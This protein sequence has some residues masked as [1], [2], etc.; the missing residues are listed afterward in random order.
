MFAPMNPPIR[1]WRDQRVWIVGASSGIGAALARA[2]LTAGAR[3][4]LSARREQALAE[5][6]GAASHPDHAM[7][8]P[9][10]VTDPASVAAAHERIVERW[11]SV[12]LTIWVAGTYEAMHPHDFRLSAARAVIETNLSIYN[13]LAV[14]LPAM[15]REGRGSLAIVSSV[16]GYRGLPTVAMAYGPTK[17]ALVSLAETLYLDLRP[18]GHGI[19]LI[20]PGF[21][22]T[23]LTSGNA[24]PMPGLLDADEAARRILA[25]FARGDFEIHFPSRLTWPMKFARVLPYRWYFA[26]IGRFTG[27][28]HAERAPK[29]EAP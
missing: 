8:V 22:E 18:H 10:D 2:L 5:V 12:D 23:R 14:L 1:D 27:S 4:A 26:L 16:T 21:V 7:T 17:A 19:Y 9:L 6:A 11:S 24:F 28:A 13:G 25:G 3:V 15:R 20:N 29:K